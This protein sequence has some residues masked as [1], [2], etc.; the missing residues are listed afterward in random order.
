MFTG[1]IAG[2][3]RIGSTRSV[4]AGWRIE[5]EHELGEE[6]VKIGESIA[7]DGCCLTAI[8]PGASQFSAEISPETL[9]RTGGLSRWRQG[10]QLNLERALR[11]GDRL[12]GHIVQ[13]HADGLVRLFSTKPLAGGWRVLRVELPASGRSW[14]IEKGSITLDGV[15]LTIADLGQ[16]WFDVALIPQTLSSTTIGQR[17]PGDRLIV[18]YD[19]FAKYAARAR[20]LPPAR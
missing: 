3:G 19:L 17:K 10:R 4:G 20:T 2:L 16:N 12:G 6:P 18:E 11:A 7:C 9:S 5:V 8:E 13:G 1:L 14:T 15:S